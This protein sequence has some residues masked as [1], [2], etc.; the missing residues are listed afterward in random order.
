MGSES[1]R[2]GYEDLKQ[3]WGGKEGF[4]ETAEG[5]DAED[6]WGGVQPVREASPVVKTV[7]EEDWEVAQR[8]LQIQQQRVV[9][10]HM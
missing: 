2:D 6:G 5:D 4:D 8:K 1:G 9:S 3:A 7:A 10:E